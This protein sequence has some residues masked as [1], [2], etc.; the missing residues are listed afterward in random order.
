M[1]PSPRLASK[2]DARPC[3][4]NACAAG[5]A[6]R[7]YA[8]GF[9]LVELMVG[10]LVSIIC[11]LAIMTAFAVYEGHKRTTTSGN[12]AQQ[13]GSYALYELERQVRTAGSGIVQGNNYSVWGCPLS[14]STSSAQVLPATK[15]LPAPFAAWPTTTLAMPV[16]VSAGATASAPDTIA[17]ISGN[18]AYQVFKVAITS[19]PAV[20]SV[21]V[22]NGFGIQAND[23]LLGILPGGTC[24]LAQASGITSNTNI[25]LVTANSP[26]TGLNTA[27]NLFDLGPQPTLSLFGV[28]TTSNNLVS[29]DLLQRPVA[30]GA[31]S[32][33]PLADGVIVMKTLYGVHTTGATNPDEVDAWV[34]PTGTWS[35]ATLTANTADAAAA[36]GE[37][38]AVR[39]AVVVQSR[40]PERSSDYTGPATL[41]LFPD[42]PAANQ[43]VIPLQ[44]QYRYKVYDTTIPVRNALITQYF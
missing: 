12:D 23:Y 22:G 43:Y 41:T 16:L 35:L 17:V 14:A 1:Y 26:T 36:V 18:P 8:H 13:N 29:Y 34:P 25:T 31:P 39:V 3:V 10:I 2:A 27:V 30:A 7:R 19:T 6:N 4:E 20:N 15:A 28:D 33:I 38:M 37:I 24:A 42:Q 11:T 21:V 44:T 5:H 9:S 32:V 40:L